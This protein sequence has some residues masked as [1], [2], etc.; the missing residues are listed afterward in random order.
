MGLFG[1]DPGA[2]ARARQLPRPL[3]LSAWW[4]DG[5]AWASTP[6]PRWG[7]NS[8]YMYLPNSI[9]IKWNILKIPNPPPSQ[10]K[11]LENAG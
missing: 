7:P 5:P 1:S 10:K 4:S 9:N 3:M 11:I 6:R 8:P 2:G